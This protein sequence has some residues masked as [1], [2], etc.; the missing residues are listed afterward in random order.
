[1]TNMGTIVTNS[2]TG[3]V[4]ENGRNASND[5]GG[6]IENNAGTV[7]SNN[8]DCTVENNTG[9]VDYNSGVVV[10]ADGGVVKVNRG[11]EVQGSGTVNINLS[12][13]DKVESGV[14]VINQ[15][16]ELIS[17]VWGHLTPSGSRASESTGTGDIYKENE[18][19]ATRQLRVW[20]ST[21]GE[22][23]VSPTDANRQIRSLAAT[24]GGANIERLENGTYRITNITKDVNLAV[25]FVGDPVPESTANNDS[26]SGKSEDNASS[27]RT[28]VEAATISQLSNVTAVLDA[29][30]KR[31]AAIAPVI[32]QGALFAAVDASGNVIPADIKHDYSSSDKDRV[33][34]PKNAL[35]MTGISLEGKETAVYYSGKMTNVSA[36]SVMTVRANTNPAK[37]EI[38]FA[39]FRNPATGMMSFLKVQV[40][41]DGTV[42]FEVPYADCEFS[43]VNIQDAKQQ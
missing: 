12:N 11:G 4:D 2:A 21:T 19:S 24:D 29:S 25:S 41:A 28:A 13:P 37:G 14:T 26:G 36:G 9:T 27:T 23:I 1:M 22:V 42:S 10:N 43:L 15:M 8:P 31:V 6:T 32:T 20:L 5:I 40:N 35:T 39:V 38:M 16:W 18:Y 3:Y 7:R 30:M 17:N 34:F 33:D